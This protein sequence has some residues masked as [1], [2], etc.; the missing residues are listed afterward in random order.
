MRT[1]LTHG[2]AVMVIALTSICAFGQCPDRPASGTVVGDAPS[3]VS[4]NGTLSAKFTMA[5]SVDVFGYMHY[6]Y[7]YLMG[8][9]VVE[10][11]T[12]RLN[13]GDKL[14]LDI[15]NQNNPADAGMMKMDMKIWE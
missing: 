14:G 9:Q 6:C 5:Q 4:Q 1:Q 12:L 11:P 10:A 7:K 13:P 2:F 3:L 8:S 15:V